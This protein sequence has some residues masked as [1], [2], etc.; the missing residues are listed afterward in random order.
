MI[1]KRNAVLAVVAVAMLTAATLA[2]GQGRMSGMGMGGNQPQ[3]MKTIHTL[4][5]EHKNITRTVKNIS[6][7]VETLT[8]SDDPK[9]KA[10]IVEHSWAMKARLEKKQP[11]RQWD[12]LFAELFKY[13]DKIKMEIA[14]TA[15]GVKV[16]ETSDDT[17][18]VKLIQ[19]HAAGVSEFVAE[20]MSS[21]HKEHPLPGAEKKDTAFAGKG[22]GV[23]TCPVTGEPVNKNIKHGFFGRTVYFCCESCLEAAK[24]NPEKFIK[25]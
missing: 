16:T 18:V 10:L 2:Q 13:A 12:P 25:P 17:Y 1:G 4:F 14:S 7:G 19:A 3:D 11:I 22:D 5:D 9:V 24:K 8:E 21:M 20:G 23:E 6:N 15:K